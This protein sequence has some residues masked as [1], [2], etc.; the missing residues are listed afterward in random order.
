MDTIYSVLTIINVLGSLYTFSYLK[1][2]TTQNYY[3]VS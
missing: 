2:K 1:L 3:P